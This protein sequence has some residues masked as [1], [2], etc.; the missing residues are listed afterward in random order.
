MAFRLADTV[1]WM[2]ANRA[3]HGSL[4]VEHVNQTPK[5]S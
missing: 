3:G 4:G 1:I 2:P 5:A